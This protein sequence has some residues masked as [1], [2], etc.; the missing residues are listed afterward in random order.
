[1]YFI[2]AGIKGIV[3]VEDRGERSTFL[4]GPAVLHL[5]FSFHLI[6]RFLRASS[7]SS[8]EPVIERQ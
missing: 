1:M 7:W 3:A 8:S 6:C 4:K 2:Y 5:S